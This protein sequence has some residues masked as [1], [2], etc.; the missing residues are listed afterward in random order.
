VTDE[1]TKSAPLAIE[2]LDFEVTCEAKGGSDGAC[3]QPAR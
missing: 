2:H 1:L 3:T